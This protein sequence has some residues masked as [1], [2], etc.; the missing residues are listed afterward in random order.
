MDTAN[1][2]AI[3]KKGKKMKY[4]KYAKKWDK[5]EIIQHAQLQAWT[6]EKV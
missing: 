6:V 2:W 3:T 5:N 1:S 4:N